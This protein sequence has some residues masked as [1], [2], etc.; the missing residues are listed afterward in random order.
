MLVCKAHQIDPHRLRDGRAGLPEGA[1]P[2]QRLLH[3]VPGA[4]CAGERL[5]Q[6]Q[7]AAIRLLGVGQPAQLALNVAHLLVGAAVLQLY[8][9]VAGGPAGEF[10]VIRQGLF[11]E[12]LLKRVELLVKADIGNL[13]QKVDGL[14]RLLALCLGLIPLTTDQ[15]RADGERHGRGDQQPCR[16]GDGHLVPPRPAAAAW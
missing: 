2:G 15:H 12:L 5:E 13:G 4:R 7:R 14:A 9:A 10:L 3:F 8:R 1:R 16:G 11:Q 6:L